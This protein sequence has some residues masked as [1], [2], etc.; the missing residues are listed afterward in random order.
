MTVAFRSIGTVGTGSTSVTPGLP[1]G[2]ADTDLVLIRVMTKPDTAAPVTPSGWTLVADVAGGG[3]SQGNSAGPSRQV[4][5]SR[6]KDA[7]WST[8]PTITV[9]NGNSSACI[10]EAWSRGGSG[11]LV[12]AATGTYGVINAIAGGSS[13]STP[14]GS[15]PGLT[16]GDGV[17]VGLSNQDDAPTWGSQSVSASGISSWDAFTE[18]SEVIETTTGTDI[19]GMLFTT[20]VVTG[21]S[22]GVP[23]VSATP[24]GSVASRGTIALVR[25]REVSA[26][27]NQTITPSGIASAETFPSGG[28]SGLL[29]VYMAVAANPPAAG[30]SDETIYNTLTAAGHTVTLALGT[31]NLPTSD[32]DVVVVT[33]SNSSGDVANAD[34]PTCPLP[35]VHMETNWTTTRMASVNATSPGS[36]GTIDILDAGN[37]HPIFTGLPDPMTYRSGTGTTYGVAAGSLASGVTPLADHGSTAGHAVVV[38][39]DTGATLT[40]GT[41]SNRR[42]EF[43]IGI[44]STTAANWTADTKTAFVN[45]C[46]WAANKTTGGGPS[47]SQVVPSQNLSPTGVGTEQAFGT[48]SATVLAPGAQSLSPASIASAESFSGAGGAP[49]AGLPGLID[50]VEPEASGGFVGPVMDSNGNMYRVTEEYLGAGGAGFGN[51]PMM[52]KSSDGGVTW[53]RMDAANSPGYGV[54]GSYNDMEAAWITHRPSRKE[55]VLTYM[56]GNSRWFGVV[57][58]TSDHATNPDTWDT[59]SFGTTS[60]VDSLTPGEAGVTAVTLST[61]DVRA[62][63]RST[64]TALIMRTMAAAGVTWGASSNIT[65]GS[66]I[67]T[68]PSAVVANSDTTYLFYRDDTNAQIRYCTISSAGVVSASARVDSGGAGPTGGTPGG[69]GNYLNNIVPPVYYDDAGTPV[70]VVAFVNASNQLRVV[71]V[72]G[73]V[74]GSEQVVSTDTVTVNPTGTG[75]STDN[76]GPSAAIAVVGTTLYAFWGDNTT[77]DLYYATRSNGGAWSARTLLADTGVGNAVHWVYASKIVKPGG[78]ISIGYTYDIGPHAD[79]DSNVTYNE[80]LVVGGGGPTVSYSAPSSNLVPTGIASAETFGTPVRTSTITLVPTAL[81]SAEA[82]GTPVRTSTIALVPVGIASAEVFGTPVR[83]STITLVPTA[84]AS[85]EAFGTPVRTSTIAL[86]PVGIASAE[87]MGAPVIGLG[88]LQVVAVG[89][90]TAEALGAPTIAASVSL[91]A[92]GIGSGE[93]FGSPTLAAPAPGLTLVPTG[94]ASAQAFGSPVIGLGAVTITPTGIPS[95]QAF[96]TPTRSSVIGLVPVGVGSAEAFGT[97]V[98]T[99]AIAVS[100]TG[101]VTGQ[102]V[103]VPTVGLGAV[104]LVPTGIASAQAVGT[105]TVGLG[106][107][108]LV[109][110]GIG[111][112]QAF[113]VASATKIASQSLSPAGIASAQVFG[114]AS[115]ENLFVGWGFP[116]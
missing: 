98:R 96:G 108:N 47:V 74:V 11:W 88:T 72:R 50:G 25:L 107:V 18:R 38:V 93:A 27:S 29:N 15:D 4:V 52:M 12:A 36:V 84:L 5:F 17:S 90:G 44:G 92:T 10:A 105:P 99:S 70:V 104:T 26:L 89:I 23:T 39:A 21:T 40:T 103:G 22:T 61:G 30:S 51:H 33:E 13:F 112:A 16:A 68:R 48:A 32:Y 49:A 6:E 114:I 69:N 28:G 24:A 87:A 102:A 75:G 3:G 19:G 63:V 101:I 45:A 81:A 83:T 67:L 65:D 97:P 31:A 7:S 66:L 20:G 35:V 42:V 77:G 64:N 59:S 109:P 85:A 37:S 58:R 46:V 60:G 113:G 82:F 56:K 110:V 115:I 100:P 86:V 9:T 94:I 57:F 55:I 71:E 53:T 8:M 116:L 91:A 78:A 1:T 34:I 41:A 62:I 80:M 111:S 76:E 54:T 106:T 43:G 2:L 14:L 79:D 95:A 73:G